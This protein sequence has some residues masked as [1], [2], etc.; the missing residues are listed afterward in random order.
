MPQERLNIKPYN[1]MRVIR[2][3]DIKLE[4]EIGRM[5]SDGSTIN[6][7]KLIIQINSFEEIPEIYNRL[8][9]I[10]KGMRDEKI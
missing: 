7:D 2:N 8:K 9:K 4:I 6:N 5:I 1:D 10:T 3:R